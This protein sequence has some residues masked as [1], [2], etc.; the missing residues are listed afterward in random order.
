MV[1]QKICDR[2]ALATGASLGISIRRKLSRGFRIVIGVLLVAQIAANCLNLAADLNAIGQGVNLLPA[3]PVF[4][5]SAIA[6]IA[7]VVA[8][9][10]GSFAMIG[11]IFKW[12]CMILLVYVGELFVSR[13]RRRRWPGTCVGLRGVIGWC[14]S[15]HEVYDGQKQSVD[16][17]RIEL[18]ADLHDL[19]STVAFRYATQDCSPL[20][21]RGSHPDDP[22]VTGHRGETSLVSLTVGG[23]RDSGIKC[24]FAARITRNDRGDL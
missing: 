16:S 20:D 3:G 8:V 12:L 18:L 1:V 15:G 13:Q 19:E 5:W 11:R 23:G 9:S 7:T 2:M 14:A 17:G 4:L 24:G 6:G 21:G 10:A 22:P